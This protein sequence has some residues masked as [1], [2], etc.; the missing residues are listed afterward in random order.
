MCTVDFIDLICEAFTNKTV[1][2]CL[3]KLNIISDAAIRSSHCIPCGFLRGLQ[4]RAPVLYA[5]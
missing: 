1:Q 4:K 2:N 5:T 3:C